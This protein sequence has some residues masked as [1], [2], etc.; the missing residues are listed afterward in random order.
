MFITPDLR[1]QFELLFRKI[2]KSL[3]PDVQKKWDGV[4]YWK[5]EYSYPDIQKE[6]IS[7]LPPSAKANY[8]SLLNKLSRGKM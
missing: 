7:E 1:S 3:H 2:I 6:I 8:V 5:D 4:I